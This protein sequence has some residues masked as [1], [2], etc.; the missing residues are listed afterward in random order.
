MLWMHIINGYSFWGIH[1]TDINPAISCFCNDH[2]KLVLMS[3]FA[4]KLLNFNTYKD[5]VLTPL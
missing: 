4:V 3:C 5:N 1:Q 2:I